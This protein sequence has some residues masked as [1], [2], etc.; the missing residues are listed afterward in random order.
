MDLHF[1]AFCGGALVALLLVC[2]LLDFLRLWLIRWRPYVWVCT[3]WERWLSCDRLD[4]CLHVAELKW[5]LY[6]LW[7]CCC[8][9]RSRR[10]VYRVLPLDASDAVDPLTPPKQR[11]RAKA[12]LAELERRAKPPPDGLNVEALEKAIL[13]AKRAGVDADRLDFARS[14]LEVAVKF[15]GLDDEPPGQRVRAGMLAVSG[16]LLAVDDET[17]KGSNTMPRVRTADKAAGPSPGLYDCRP[18]CGWCTQGL[19]GVIVGAAVD[20]SPL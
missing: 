5:H 3:R 1:L 7:M 12:A 6:G 9:C 20:R 13:R 11:R 10:L 14:R 17:T 2:G 16:G 19:L 4:H 8:C 18:A 15:Q